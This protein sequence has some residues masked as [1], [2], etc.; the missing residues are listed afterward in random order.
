MA[1]GEDVT[2][3]QGAAIKRRRTE[4]N[5]EDGGLV[6]TDGPTYT[7]ETSMGQ[8]GENRDVDGDNE[9]L[10]R[11]SPLSRTSRKN[12]TRTSTT[13]T[14]TRKR[15]SVSRTEYRITRRFDHQPKGTTR[16]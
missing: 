15:V 1:G 12:Y 7:D 10:R 8:S 9:P 14:L 13:T 16:M 5:L 2:P 6:A 4:A 11:N 3:D